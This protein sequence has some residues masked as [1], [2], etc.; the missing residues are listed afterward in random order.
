[1]IMAEYQSEVGN[2]M[3][4]QEHGQGFSLASLLTTP[5]TVELQVYGRALHCDTHCKGLGTLPGRV[6]GS[7]ILEHGMNL[8]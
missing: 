5:Y 1:M 4:L 8:L 7:H 3:G 2:I 6:T